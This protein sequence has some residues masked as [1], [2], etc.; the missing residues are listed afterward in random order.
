MNQQEKLKHWDRSTSSG[1]EVFVK[2]ADENDHGVGQS[3]E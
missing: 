2:E 1:E 3:G